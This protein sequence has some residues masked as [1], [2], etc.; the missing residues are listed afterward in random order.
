MV[1]AAAL[2]LWAAPLRAQQPKFDSTTYKRANRPLIRWGEALGVAA[3]TG[4]AYALDQNLRDRVHDPTGGVGH[5]L[6][7]VGN[8]Q[9]GPMVYPALLTLMVAAKVIPSK[10][11]YGVTSR[12]FKSVA[13]GG[14]AALVIKTMVGRERPSQSPDHPHN[15]HPFTFH[16]TS[17][18]SGHTT[19]AFALATSFARETH[20]KAFDVAFFSLATLTAWSRMHDDRHWASDVVAGAGL[21]ILSARFVHRREARILLGKQTVG[22]NFEF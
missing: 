2:V 4:L 5:T 14:A 6:A 9:G 21:G 8:A 16:D 13:V 20:N 3:T 15:F 19:V 22:V 18:P 17:F 10:G 12:A 11:M 7:D 1:G